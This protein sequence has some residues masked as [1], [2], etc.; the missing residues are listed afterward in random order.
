MNGQVGFPLLR[1]LLPHLD[2]GDV[3]VVDAGASRLADA[4]ADELRKCLEV[5]SGQSQTTTA[6]RSATSLQCALAMPRAQLENV[7]G[8]VV[9]VQQES[10]GHARLRSMMQLLEQA[11]WPLLA[12]VYDEQCAPVRRW[13]RRLQRLRRRQPAGGPHA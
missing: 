8:V 3:L 10:D 12:W 2:D 4:L 5:W 1:Q 13:N 9:V 7:A 6:I 11:R